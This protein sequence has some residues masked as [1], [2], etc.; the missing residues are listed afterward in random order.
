MPDTRGW[1]AVSRYPYG[2]MIPYGRCRSPMS[3]PRS[4]HYRGCVRVRALGPVAVDGLADV[5]GPRQRA[6]LA[7]LTLWRGREVGTD[8]LVSAIW[9][10][11]PPRTAEHTAQGYVFRL[12]RAGI[13][14]IGTANGYRLDTETDIDEAYRLAAAAR[15]GPDDAIPRYRAALL[16]FRGAA[17]TELPLLPEAQAEAS[18]LGEFREL[19]VE[20]LIAALLDHGDA[21]GAVA[22]ARSATNAEP[23]RERRWELLILALYR[24]GRQADA[25]DAYSRARQLLLDE[26]GIDPSPALRRLVQ[27]VLAQDPALDRVTVA[28]TGTPSAPNRLPGT[29][30]RLIGRVRDAHVLARA[31]DRTRLVTLVGPPGVGKTRLSVEFARQWQGPVYFVPLEELPGTTSVGEALLA[32]IAPASR[33]RQSRSGIT[34]ALGD[35]DAL[36]VLDGCEERVAE[37]AVE[38]AAILAACPGARMVATSR[39]RLNLRDEGLI[40]LGPLESDAAVDLLVDRAQLVDPDFVLTLDQ[41]PAAER[42]CALV[43]RLPLGIELV[44]GHLRLLTPAQLADRVAADLLRW[45]GGGSDRDGGVWAAVR[46]SVDRLGSAERLLLSRMAIFA[47]DADLELIRDVAAP[48][49]PEE[50]LFDRV[51]TLVEVSLVQVRSRPGGI[52]YGLLNSVAR[53][54]LATLPAAEVVATQARYI[55]AVLARTRASAAQL[56]SASRSTALSTLDAIQPHVRAVLAAGLSRSGTAR[57]ALRVMIDLTEYWLGRR[58][59]EGLGWLERLLAAADPAPELRAATLREMGHLTY[60]LTDFDRGTA[61]LREGLAICETIGDAHGEGRILRRLGAVHAATDDVV[62]ARELLER[63]VQRLE[64][65]D[66]DGAEV[67]TTLLHLGC[68]LADEGESEK[69]LPLLHRARR[70]A[71][72]LGDPLAEGHATSALSLAAWKSADLHLAHH[73]G[74]QA[75][76]TFETLGHRPTQGTVAARLASI[77]RGLGLT[78]DSYRYARLAL[79]AGRDAGTR[80]TISH[81]YICLARLDL[82]RDMLGDATRGLRQALEVLRPA[83]DRWVLV[84]VLESLGRL[85]VR[86]ADPAAGTMLADAAAIRVDINQPVPPTEAGDVARAH[87][88]AKRITGSPGLGRTDPGPVAVDAAGLLAML[89]DRLAASAPAVPAADSVSEPPGP[90]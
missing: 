85:L 57:D 14:I 31:L 83:D 61:L 75:L 26:L 64:S 39:R 59:T 66:P 65:V 62:Q 9:P 52:R 7:A 29:V 67:G 88:A 32:A 84:D 82:D 50:L 36:V 13:P 2:R 17:Y 38:V 1:T 71:G 68:L 51:A 3:S 72:A 8:R 10:E 23:Y 41:R 89:T 48:D 47:A 42:L 79:E 55:E 40:P 4:R 6:L 15:S 78:E 70:I 73:L 12:R 28:E 16:L 30:T 19:L 33:A 87:E 37:T 80:T 76:A 11:D 46:D 25:L 74:E 27:A 35:R 22:E 86:F 90:G 43:D 53:H 63:A 44:A 81:G 5:G 54:A 21:L 49:D 77:T 24:A 20:E 69:A 34:A 45:A 60:W 58:P 56:R 18:R